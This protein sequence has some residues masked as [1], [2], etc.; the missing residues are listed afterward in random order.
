M[1]IEVPNNIPREALT[2][3]L[4]ALA[5]D[6]LM[7]GH[8]NSEWTGHSPIIEEDIAF[9]NIAQDELGHS[10]AWYTLLGQMNGQSPD[11]MVF[12]RQWQEFTSCRFVTY[13]KGDFAYTVTR[14]YFFDVAE[15]IRLRSMERSVFRPM[16]EIA[17]KVSAEE[18]YHLLH[19]RGLVE[20]LGDAT[21]ESHRRMQEAVDLAFPQA[22]GI[23][24]QFKEEDALVETGV[25]VESTRLQE[26]W[27]ETIVPI[28]KGVSL[29][30]PADKKGN[31]YVP[32]IS[33]DSGGRVGRHSSDLRQLVE[34]MQLVYQMAPSGRW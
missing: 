31:T 25:I 10:L 29:E 34:D 4:L 18:A 22:L 16:K 2:G 1:A 19:S 28:L 7:L 17:A 11:K 6:E 3:C 32:R 20:R 14:Q 26:Q 8:R 21:E 27:L 15:E 23:F 30:V 5:D 9:A 12:E 33:A 13:P 24:E